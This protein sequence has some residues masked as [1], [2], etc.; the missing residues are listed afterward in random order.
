MNNG[1]AR[2]VQIVALHAQRQNLHGSAHTAGGDWS[3]DG[4]IDM[5][6]HG[7]TY[8][9]GAACTRSLRE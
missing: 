9:A 6:A 5:D 2:D 8:T 3:I 4:L 7:R 1:R